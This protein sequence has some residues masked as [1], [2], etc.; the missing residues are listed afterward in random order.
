MTAG[1]IFF[2]LYM[3]FSN[4]IRSQIFLRSL[5]GSFALA[6]HC[7]RNPSDF[8]AIVNWSRVLTVD[9]TSDCLFFMCS[10]SRDS[11][12]SDCFHECVVF[13]KKISSFERRPRVVFFPV[14][15][16]PESLFKLSDF[17][18]LLK[19]LFRRTWSYWHL[20]N[21]YLNPLLEFSFF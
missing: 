7:C 8:S 18:R 6:P 11:Y 9:I 4:W 3:V 10:W 21:F 20:L 15:I 19:A 2:S 12:Y 5:K 14:I 16:T 17:F 1:F 13:L